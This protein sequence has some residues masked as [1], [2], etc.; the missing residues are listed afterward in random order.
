MKWKLFLLSLAAVFMSGIDVSAADPV[1]VGGLDFM[2]V[3]NAVIETTGPDSLKVL[4]V[5]GPGCDEYSN[6]SNDVSAPYGISVE[7][8]ESQSGV[9]I[10]PDA[11]CRADNR[12]MWATAYGSIDGETDRPITFIK[13]TRVAWGLY[14]I[15]ADFTALGATSFTYQVSCH[16]IV[17]LHSTN[18]GPSSWVSTIDV[19]AY[20]PRVNPFFR[21]GVVMGAVVEFPYG[22]RF[23]VEDGG[24]GV[25]DQF[26]IIPEGVTNT[27]D[28]LSRVE[29]F[30]SGNLPSF[31]VGDP[32][33][34][35]FGRPHKALGTV[36]FSAANG[37]LTA[38]P[39]GA[40]DIQGPSDGILVDF[41][42]GATKWAVQTEPFALD[43][44]TAG[45]RLSASGV[46]SYNLQEGFLSAGFAKSND[47]VSLYG[48]F[49]S[50]SSN[51][52]LR[53]YRG[54]TL[55]GTIQGPNLFRLASLAVTN[56]MVIG[57]VASPSSLT[58]SLAEPTVA[59]A[60]DGGTAEADRFEFSAA[61]STNRIGVLD[62]AH[63][64]GSD[65]GALTIISEV[66][67]EPTVPELKLDIT[68]AA[69]A[70]EVSW[71]YQRCPF[72]YLNVRTNVAS[73]SYVGVDSPVVHNDF[74]WHLLVNP[75]N[76]AQ[77]FYLQ[78]AYGYYIL[79]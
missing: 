63:V 76:Q 42:R 44:P 23:G 49:Y 17:T 53:L 56:P 5:G 8:G 78:H 1:R 66:T 51:T 58:F 52:L 48:D 64:R 74:R 38:G 12:S 10:S 72:Y 45:L 3:S 18:R 20:N 39:F 50:F 21:D 70:V 65:V 26:F 57:W 4:Q 77:F 33:L 15:E 79:P 6:G 27:V 7:L 71:P 37:R 34:G 54:N 61:E 28:Y 59:T 73:Y 2:V 30:G 68:R 14:R 25:G 75:T 29:I 16:G 31:S 60:Y 24:S 11:G 43:Q 32:R 36:N 67:E 22:T 55:S 46:A 41:K 69:G 13:G 40:S 62:S 9:Y 47:V 19:E 35:M